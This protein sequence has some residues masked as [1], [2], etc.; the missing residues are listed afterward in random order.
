MLQNQI[1][2]AHLLDKHFFDDIFA[3]LVALAGLVTFGI[4]PSYK[5][6]ATLARDIADSV[7]PC[8][9]NPILSSPD[10]DIHTLIKQIGTTYYSAKDLTTWWQ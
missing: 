3:F 9:Q 8:D 5:C 1:S 6:L 2:I 4:C 7:K 10:S